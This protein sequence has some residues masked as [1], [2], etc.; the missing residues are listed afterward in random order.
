MEPAIRHFRA[1]G[2]SPSPKG[3]QRIA[4]FDLEL[5]SAITL[6]G[7]RLVKTPSGRLEIYPPDRQDGRRCASLAPAFR[8]QISQLA[9]HHM[10]STVGAATEIS[11]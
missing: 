2:E 5:G 11:A 6:H 4:T 8:D 1:A 7:L 3:F 9:A 10:E